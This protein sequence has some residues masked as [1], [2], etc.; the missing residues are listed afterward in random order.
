MIRLELPRRAGTLN[1][2]KEG[3]WF[4]GQ[5]FLWTKLSPHHQRRAI[6]DG[7]ERS[8]TGGVMWE[9][10]PEWKCASVSSL[11]DN[12]RGNFSTTVGVDD[13]TTCRINWPCHPCSQNMDHATKSQWLRDDS[14]PCRNASNQRHEHEQRRM[15]VC[16]RQNILCCN[17]WFDVVI[18]CFAEKP[19]N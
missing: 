14:F 11:L 13:T 12:W 2:C 16:P 6:V 9:G 17:C 3:R 15:M 4:E 10:K 19:N 8:S 1:I 7:Y 18:W 5:N